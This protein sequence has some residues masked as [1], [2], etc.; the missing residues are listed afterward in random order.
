MPPTSPPAAS[1]PPDAPPAPRPGGRAFVWLCGGALGFNLLMV[2]F[3]LLLIAWNGLSYFWPRDLVAFERSTGG[4]LLGEVHARETFRPTGTDTATIAGDLPWR[5]QIKVANRDLTGT[6]FLW[7]DEREVTATH[8][9]A[10]AVHVERLEW[11]AFHGFLRDV[12]RGNEVLAAGDAAWPKLLELID[13][14]RA[15]R[16]AVLE[17]ERGELGD[18]NHELEELRLDRR[19]S[20]AGTRSAEL[21][22]SQAKLDARF[23]ALATRLDEMRVVLGAETARFVTAD[24]RDHDLPIGGI[25][26]AL[27]PNELSPLSRL[28]LWASRLAAFLVDEPRESNTEGGI[29]PALFGTVMMVFLMSVAVVPLGVLAALYLREYARQGPLVRIVRIAVNNLAGVPSIVFGV[30]GLGFFVYGLGGTIDRWFHADALPQPTF[31]TGGIL[32]AALTLALLTV[33]VVI[34][35]TEEGLAAV[36]RA[37]REGSLALG[38]TKFETTWRVVLPAAAP[39]MLTGV[40]L[41]IARASGEVAPLM[42]VG[43]VKLAPALPIDHHAPFVHLDRKFMHLGFHIFDVG[44]QSPNVEATKPLVFATALVLLVLVVAMNL[45]AIRLRNKLR[46]RYATSAV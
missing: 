6:D 35:A 14:K 45:V 7:L 4:T 41:A 11:G 44:F 16:E 2:L 24:G 13:E 19:R 26:H 31:G 34:V 28:G 21:D 36:P 27:R 40:I 43:M 42:I 30:F 23:V 20:D 9:P 10:D 3:Q 8:R 15:Q 33:P 29:F 32:W 17:L 39:G 46:Q 18:V 1:R 38:A 12:R 22:A 5:T 37:V 25:V